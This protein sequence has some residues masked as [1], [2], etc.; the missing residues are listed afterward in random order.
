MLRC[1]E[2]RDVAA[3]AVSAL[4]SLFNV[5]DLDGDGHVSREEFRDAMAALAAGTQGMARPDDRICDE[6]FEEID[7]DASGQLS[8]EVRQPRHTAATC[9]YAACTDCR[10]HIPRRDDLVCMYQWP[11]ALRR[12]HMHP[13]PLTLPCAVHACIRVRGRSF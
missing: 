12:S 7:A 9:T 8:Y 6:L 13:T 5:V 10:M 1:V 2:S 3:R 11:F 4:S